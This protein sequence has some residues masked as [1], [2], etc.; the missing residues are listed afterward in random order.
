MP[1]T[2]T[3]AGTLLLSLLLSCSRLIGPENPLSICDDNGTVDLKPNAERFGFFALEFYGNYPAYLDSFSSL[4]GAH[5]GYILWFQQ[6]DDPFPAAVVAGAAARGISAVISLN[7][8]S[9]NLDSVRND[10]LLREIPLGIWDSTLAAFAAAAAHS[11]NVMYLRFGYEMNGD[12]FPWG[13]KPADFVSAWNH[14]RGIFNDGGADNVRW[15][16]SPNVLWE[17]RTFEGNILPF[18]PGDSS[19]DIVGL[20]G[21]N[22][23]DNCDQW[24]HWQSFREIFG[25]SLRGMK[26]LGKPLWIT[27]IGCVADPRRPAWIEDALFFMDNNPCVDAMLWFNAHKPS[28]PDY[29]LEADSASLTLIK[30]WLLP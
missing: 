11:G 4:L 23:G 2:R 9:L 16:F 19:V 5:P 15:V 22:C 27:E 1:A 18:F 13:N 8:K 20:D 28:K 14:A 17:D 3:A 6:I 25:R 12:W 24:H 7:I 29:R 26:T 10:T 30:N 21:Y